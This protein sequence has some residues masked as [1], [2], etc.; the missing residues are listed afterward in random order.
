MINAI[1]EIETGTVEEAP[2][3]LGCGSQW[4]D[5][6]GSGWKCQ[7][8]GEIDG[9]EMPESQFTPEQVI[10]AEVFMYQAVKTLGPMSLGRATDLLLDNFAWLQ[11]S[12]QARHLLIAIM[13][14]IKGN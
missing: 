10:E 6:T 5:W 9:V 3:C 8:C 4:M 7:E 1:S 12:V 14:A 2:F 13:P 11:D